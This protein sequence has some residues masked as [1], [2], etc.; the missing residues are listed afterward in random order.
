MIELLEKAFNAAAML[1]DAEHA[2]LAERILADMS[3]D[4]RWDQRFVDH[5]ELLVMMAE[6]AVQER[7]VGETTPLD[8]QKHRHRAF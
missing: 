1:P 3:A 7:K 4:T 6:E 2:A 8:F 5:P